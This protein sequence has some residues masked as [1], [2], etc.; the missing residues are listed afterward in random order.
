M[1]N[2]LKAAK[3]QSCL[4]LMMVLFWP[5]P[6]QTLT[7]TKFDSIIDTVKEYTT[8]DIPMINCDYYY[9]NYNF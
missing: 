4:Y 2:V 1:T 9:N 6:Y 5:I 8:E 7:V 3:K